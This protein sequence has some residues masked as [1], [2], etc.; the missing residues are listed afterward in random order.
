MDDI[1]IQFYKSLNVSERTKRNYM[2]AL[3]SAFIKNMLL[4]SSGSSDLFDITDLKV[5]WSLYLKINQ[6][7][8]NVYNHRRHSAAIMK[9]IR[10]L[11][12]GEKYGKR[13][14]YG[15]PKSKSRQKKSGSL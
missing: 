8:V 15:R 4:D 7:P 12:H 2:S 3:N 11:N 10:F 13:V 6:H 1:K 14:D 5:L 9:Y